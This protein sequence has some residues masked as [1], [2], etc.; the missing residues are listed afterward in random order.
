M[1]LSKNELQVLAQTT[2]GNST[3]ES[4]A[5]KLNKDISTIYRTKNDLVK[6]D[7]ITF[8]NKTIEPRR[9]PHVSIL[10]QMITEHPNIIELLSDSGIPILSQLVETGTIQQIQERTNLKKSMIYKK[11]QQAKQIS[12]IQKSDENTYKINKQI[13]K[14]L[15]S[16]LKFI[17]QYEETTD[18]RIPADSKIYYKK[19]N[20]ILF[21]NKRN[22]DATK[23]GFSAYEHFGIKILLP[24]NYYYLPQ[25]K[26]DT[27]D[28]FIH[29]IN[30]TE[31][32]M[33]SRNLTFL[34]LFYLK[35]K[36]E[37]DHIHHPIIKKIRQV[38]N[39]K[40]IQ[41]YPTYEEIMEKVDLYDIKF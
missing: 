25:K 1:R 15:Y 28:I 39:G 37:L 10:L 18:V 2:Q 8:T 38:I 7:L 19:N 3:I 40:R 4:I 33:N 26:L 16:L 35:F 20:E 11:I 41:D 32:E 13:W 5:T 21:S 23:T 14:D 27:K 30:I 29:S 31:K 22:V 34:S 9:L 36:K 17:K 24:T 6:K 12:A